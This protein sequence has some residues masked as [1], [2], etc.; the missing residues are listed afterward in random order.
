MYNSGYP[1][2]RCYVTV[3]KKRAVRITYEER[4]LSSS[5]G[6]P[7]IEAPSSQTFSLKDDID[8]Y[9]ISLTTSVTYKKTGVTKTYHTDT[10]SLEDILEQDFEVKTLSK[11]RIIIVPGTS[12]NQ[13][14]ETIQ[15][16]MITLYETN[17]NKASSRYTDVALPSCL[18]RWLHC[19]GFW[20][21][22]VF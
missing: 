19:S 21:S 17:P 22:P 1:M 15:G 9:R 13:V 6:S 5:S 12:C 16:T 2:Y 3:P 11:Y 14:E 7:C 20:M 10:V 4:R 8:Q 18:Q